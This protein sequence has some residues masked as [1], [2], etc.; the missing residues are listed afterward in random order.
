MLQ[1]D[2]EVVRGPRTHLLH[3]FDII[4]HGLVQLADVTAV[5]L[6]LLAYQ[7]TRFRTVRFLSTK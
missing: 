2:V 7:S 1:M 3:G 5:F 4:F 6:P